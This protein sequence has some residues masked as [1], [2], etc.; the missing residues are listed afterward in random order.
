VIIHRV[1]HPTIP[2]ADFKPDEITGRQRVLRWFQHDVPIPNDCRLKVEDER[3]GTFVL[4]AIYVSLPESTD[5]TGVL[6]AKTGADSLAQAIVDEI[7][8]PQVC[9]LTRDCDF[10]IFQNSPESRAE[11]HRKCQ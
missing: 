6:V 5:E 9:S 10:V 7:E 8:V 4:W 1:K 11:C 3:D 2:V